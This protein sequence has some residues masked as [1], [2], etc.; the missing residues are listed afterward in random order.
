[1]SETSAAI[2]AKGL[3]EPLAHCMTPITALDNQRRVWT[4]ADF[5]GQVMRLADQLPDSA[6][7][8]NLCENRYLFLLA[9]CA[10]LV[11]GQRTLLP[12]NRGLNTQAQLVG[13]HADAC[14]L[15]DGAEELCPHAPNL[16]LNSLRLLGAPASS[17]PLISL[18]SVAAIAFTS[19]STGVPQANPKSW[20]T[21]IES[22]RMNARYM[23][24]DSGTETSLLATVPAQH[25][26]GMETSILFPLLSPVYVAD[27]RPLFPQDIVVRL[28]ALPTP[29]VLVST[30]VHLRALLRSGLSLPRVDRV[31]CATAP[32]ALGLAEEIEQR[33]ADELVE[34]YGC[35]E[36]GSMA[37]RRPTRQKFWTLFDGL[38]FID[39]AGDIEIEGAHLPL[40][41]PI[42]DR[43]QRL[44]ER[45]FDLI[46]RCDDMLEVA[47]KRGSLQQLN[48]ILLAAPGV[49]DGVVFMPEPEEHRVVRPRALVVSDGRTT[50]SRIQAYFAAR[51]DPVFVPRPIHFVNVLPREDSGKLQRAKLQALWQK[52]HQAG[53]QLKKESK[54][55]I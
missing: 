33:F 51:L 39:N 37:Y 21:F 23:L 48:Q 4:V 13:S 2:C 24:Q 34:V 46:G 41:V 8:I 54:R 17:I 40:R 45:S 9:F 55:N 32:L 11:K 22:S 30:P 49:V 12:Q 36:V 43:L 44:D 29:R 7:A 28:G 38:H 16:N 19:G 53:S 26:W 6:Y 14:I 18:D 10:A 31:L 50:K 1:M 20:R 5:L 47:G 42:S 35:S 15:H 52:L 27:S 25:M 3:H